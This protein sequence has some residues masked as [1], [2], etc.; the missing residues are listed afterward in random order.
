MFA[1]SGVQLSN[2]AFIADDGKRHF[3]EVVRNFMWC[4]K[5]GS[6]GEGDKEREVTRVLP[7]SR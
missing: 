4:K 5:A 6:A 3:H 7:H 2:V 1:G